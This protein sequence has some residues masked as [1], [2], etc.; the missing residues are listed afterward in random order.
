M[1]IRLG[2]AIAAAVM[3]LAGAAGAT[4]VTFDDLSGSGTVPVDYAGI[5]WNGD[6]TYYDGPQDPFNPASA[7]T[8]VYDVVNE[9]RFNFASP[10][11]F[12]GADF[13]GQDFA[14]LRFDLYLAGALVGSSSSLTT[15]ATP[16]FLSSGYG[17]LV[18][19]VRVVSQTPDHFVMDNVTYNT[20]PAVVPEPATWAMMLTG[21]FGLG[22]MLRTRRR[23][24]AAA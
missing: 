17:G 6:W 2:A 13:A 12:D 3:G 7:P 8:R 18:D 21:F 24:C 19:E 4:V 5:T 15:S 11:T 10:V 22:A 23:T 16:S 20:N 14:T 9:G 1:R